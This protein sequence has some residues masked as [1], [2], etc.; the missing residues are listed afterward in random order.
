[1]VKSNTNGKMQGSWSY[2]QELI[3]G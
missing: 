2:L 1:M 3:I